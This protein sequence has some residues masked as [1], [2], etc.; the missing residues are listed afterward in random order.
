MPRI[1]QRTGRLPGLVLDLSCSVLISTTNGCGSKAFVRSKFEA[2][3]L[4][5]ESSK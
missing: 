3:E 2:V 5:G 4:I 1:E